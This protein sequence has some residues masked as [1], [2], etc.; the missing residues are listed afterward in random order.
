MLL[1]NGLSFFGR[2]VLQTSEIVLYPIDMKIVQ[3]NKGWLSWTEVVLETKILKAKRN[4]KNIIFE[5]NR[6][7]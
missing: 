4:T 6:I 2:S 1:K 5:Q 7:T 3:E